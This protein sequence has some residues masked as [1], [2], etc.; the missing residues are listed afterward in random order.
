MKKVFHILKGI[1]KVLIVAIVIVCIVVFVAR[2]INWN[3]NK[4][5]TDNGIQENLYVEL[6]GIKQYIQIRGENTLNPIIIFLHGGPGSNT[7]YIS[8]YYQ[9]E[10]E[11]N[12]TIVNWDQRGCGRTYYKNK[13]LN[14]QTDLSTELLLEDLNDLTD[15]LT[16]RFNQEKVIIMG[17]SWGTILGTLYVE[18]YSE[19]VTAYVG[20]GQ[21]VNGLQGYEVAVNEASER[22]TALGKQEDAKIMANAFKVFAQTKDIEELDIDNYDQMVLLTRNNLKY[23][24]A[25]SNVA[26]LWAGLSSP[27]MSFTDINWF[28]AMA[29]NERAFVLQRPL[30]DYCIFKLDIREKFTTFDVPM[31]YISGSEDWITPV[32]M[33]EKYVDMIEAPDKNVKIVKNTGH[34]L[35]FDN[36][37]AFCNAVEEVLSGIKQ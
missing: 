5:R 20:V 9:T 10:L 35:M 6:G 31:Y 23:E 37:E 27:E 24:G 21:F 29:S 36:P 11:Q 19:K 2:F 8:E 34:S 16:E 30:M 28:F 32:V 14:I 26:T 13:N 18:Q 15:Y 7:T 17:H 22:L 4:I 3:K 33:M 25:I 1:G 12:Y